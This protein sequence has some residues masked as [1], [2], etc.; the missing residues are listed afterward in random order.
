MRIR[1]GLKIAKQCTGDCIL[2]LQGDPKD[3]TSDIN[4][5]VISIPLDGGVTEYLATVLSQIQPGRKC[6]RKNK[7]SDRERKHFN[8]RKRVG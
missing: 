4:V 7:K 5:R 2:T 8:N 1:E 6:K 3:G